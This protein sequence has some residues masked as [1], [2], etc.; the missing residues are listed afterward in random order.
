MAGQYSH[1]TLGQMLLAK[2]KK[3]RE[4]VA[5]PSGVPEL[6]TSCF[7]KLVSSDGHIFIC[8]RATVCVSKVLKPLVF[9]HLTAPG[10]PSPEMSIAGNT[11]VL[12]EGGNDIAPPAV[13]YP[14]PSKIPL[15]LLQERKK[16]QEDEI[17]KPP[18]HPA[19][20]SVLLS[21]LFAAGV[22]EVALDDGMGATVIRFPYINGKLLEIVIQY[23]HYKQRYEHAA[24]KRPPFRID[25]SVALELLS[26]ASKLQC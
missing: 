10:D 12:V 21:N 18:P 13:V 15:T 17:N 2:K 1:L 5:L 24:D 26:I 9:P 22:G 16:E 6:D 4:R 25:P 19:P 3:E 8:H 14:Q 23:F 11:D 7:V 20:A